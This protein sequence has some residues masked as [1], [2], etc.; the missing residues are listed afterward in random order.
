MR[1]EIKYVITKK[2]YEDIKNKLEK[3]LDKDSHS[4]NN[5]KYSIKTIYFDNIYD[6]LLNENINGDIYRKKFRIRIYNNDISNI[7]LEKKER[8]G[9]FVYKEREQI[10]LE[11]VEKICDGKISKIKLDTKLKKELYIETKLKFLKPVIVIEYDRVAFENKKVNFRLTLDSKIYETNEVGKFKDV[12]RKKD[13]VYILEV[14]Y[15]DIIPKVVSDLIKVTTQ[16]QGY[17]KYKMMRL[18]K[19]KLN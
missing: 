11:D 2:E 15:K 4:C 3:V 13:N 14:K 8:L 1:K 18:K 6:Q 7:F 16:R 9:E 19:C 5:E 17:S 10:N 12:F